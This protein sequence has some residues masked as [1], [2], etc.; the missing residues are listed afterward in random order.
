MKRLIL[1]CT[2]MNTN[3]KDDKTQTRSPLF[4]SL[5]IRVHLSAFVD[6]PFSISRAPRIAIL[7]A[8]LLSAPLAK[9]QD[10]T[11]SAAISLKESLTQIGSAY[12]K[13]SGDHLQ[14][15]FDASGKLA[16]QI[17]QGAPVDAFVSA[18]DQQMNKLD[19]A[20]KIAADTR[21]VVVNNS[22]VL[23]APAD[24][25]DAPTSFTDLAVDHG[26]K[27]AIGEP[28]TVP[29]GRYAMQT[30]KSLALDQAVTA[31]LVFG[32]SVRQVLTYVERDEVYAGIV[33]ATDAAQ[34]G[35]KVKVIAV[36]DPATHEVIEYPA[37]V[38][39]GSPHAAAARKFL[40]Y[41]TTDSAKVIFTAHG[42]TLPPSTVRPTP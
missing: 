21:R 12:E 40:D 1:P 10:I 14:F 6:K 31:R 42:F 19:S 37:A 16:A 41:L 23:I 32:E 36:A 8:F 17:R 2:R 11:V 30:L 35:D 4:S 28:K 27:I 5:F 33:Y 20:G 39:A 3:Q 29:A 38:V 15:N 26:K 25:K 18:D 22:L 13:S 24:E 7:L 34:A 9:A